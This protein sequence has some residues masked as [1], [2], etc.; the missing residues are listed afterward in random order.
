[1]SHGETNVIGRPRRMHP[2][3]HESARGAQRGLLVILA[4][5]LLWVA[6]LWVGYHVFYP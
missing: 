1:M 5:A 4:A 6:A 3:F 2:D